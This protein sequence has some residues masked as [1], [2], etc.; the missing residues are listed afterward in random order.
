MALVPREPNHAAAWSTWVQ[1]LIRSDR[2]TFI[3]LWDGGQLLSLKVTEPSAFYNRFVYIVNLK[4]FEDFGFPVVPIEENTTAVA[5][6]K[7]NI[8]QGM[9]KTA[10][11]AAMEK[12][13]GQVKGQYPDSLDSILAYVQERG[14][15][16]TQQSYTNLYEH[17]GPKS[18]VCFCF[19]DNNPDPVYQN[20]EL[21]DLF[22]YLQPGPVTGLTLLRDHTLHLYSRNLAPEI[23]GRRRIE[24]LGEEEEEEQELDVEQAIA[25]ERER[26]RRAKEREREYALVR[27]REREI[28]RA[29]AL[30]EAARLEKLRRQGK[31][32][33][34]SPPAP[35]KGGPPAPPAPGTLPRPGF[36]PIIFNRS[37]QILAQSAVLRKAA[38]EAGINF[39]TYMEQTLEAVAEPLA[40][41]IDE[42]EKRIKDTEEQRKQADIAARTSYDRSVKAEAAITGVANDKA[43]LEAQ[44]K[45]LNAVIDGLTAEKEATLKLFNSQVA[46]VSTNFANEAREKLEAQTNAQA[47]QRELEEQRAK[48][49]QAQLDLQNARDGIELE[50]ADCKTTRLRLVELNDEIAALRASVSSVSGTGTFTSESVLNSMQA[51][52][53]NAQDKQD[54]CEERTRESQ[55]RANLFETQYE[56][57]RQERDALKLVLAE[58]RALLLAE[59][60]DKAEITRF[61]AN[62]QNTID[63]KNASIATLGNTVEARRNSEL[64]L[65]DQVKSLKEQ[66]ERLSRESQRVQE[67]AATYYRGEVKTLSDKLIQANHAAELDRSKLIESQRVALLQHQRTTTDIEKENQRLKLQVEAARSETDQVKEQLTSLGDQFAIL[68]AEIE[69]GMPGGATEYNTLLGTIAELPGGG[70]EEEEEASPFSTTSSEPVTPLTYPPQREERR[71]QPRSARSE[72]STPSTATEYSEPT[73]LDERPPA[74]DAAAVIQTVAKENINLTNLFTAFGAEPG[75]YTQS[76]SKGKGELEELNAKEVETLDHLMAQG[77]VVIGRENELGPTTLLEE[78]DPYLPYISTVTEERTKIGEPPQ[79]HIA[80][81]LDK[82][83]EVISKI[84][85]AASTGNN[86]PSTR[87]SKRMVDAAMSL[88]FA[89]PP[90]F[91]AQMVKYTPD[92]LKKQ[93]N[94]LWLLGMK[95]VLSAITA[96]EASHPGS[97]KGLADLASVKQVGRDINYLFYM[98][99]AVSDETSIILREVTK[100]GR[101][102]GLYQ[103][104]YKE[105]TRVLYDLQSMRLYSLPC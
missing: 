47:F 92:R 12:L 42:L 17:M 13:F 90:F 4:A 18:F 2:E 68:R 97:G 6:W 41:R 84:D 28:E 81:A 89:L 21:I 70:I 99:T 79:E 93:R 94:L 7:Q 74:A 22:Y 44:I 87:D 50:K 78:F 5:A 103:K 52:L 65:E 102:R 30:A 25:R 95:L 14:K 98:Y 80:T 38:Y 49:A 26:G 55:Q 73:A 1:D 54:A 83:N 104:R 67:E 8:I 66:N 45:R 9:E 76:Q 72:P 43:N 61:L 46:R 53:K 23:E 96:G 56:N 36:D 71:N 37:P 40:T 69:S 100:I 3:K 33:P 59:R 29:E 75:T 62:A 58:A 32:G 39:D 31:G 19:K 77:V 24:G 34:P 88:L 11:Y 51:E 20:Y 35:G 57:A 60:N 91:T 15:K 63:E 27:E 10:G 101:G 64:L 86:K 105:H 82:I 48:L 85:W 16:H